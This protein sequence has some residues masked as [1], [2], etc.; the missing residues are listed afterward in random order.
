MEQNNETCAICKMD[1]NLAD[2]FPCVLVCGHKVC[3]ACRDKNMEQIAFCE[4]NKKQIVCPIC[5]KN[6]VLDIK[7]M[8]VQIQSV[9]KILKGNS[10]GQSAGGGPPSVFYC[11]KHNEKVSYCLVEES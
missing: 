8:D 10:A 2:R 6:L 5:N 7:D 1:M 3:L 11:E 9:K 4:D